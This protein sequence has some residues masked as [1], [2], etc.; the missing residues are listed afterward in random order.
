M[1]PPGI[2]DLDCAVAD[3]TDALTTATDAY[4]S[5]VDT[6]WYIDSAVSEL[7]DALDEAATRGRAAGVPAAL[8]AGA[9]RVWSAGRVELLQTAGQIADNLIGW[10][11]IHPERAA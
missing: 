11:S 2:A 5:N 3:L 7:R 10:L 6:G 8:L 1:T 9:S 4:E